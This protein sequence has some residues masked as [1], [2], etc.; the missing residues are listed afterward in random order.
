[1]RVDSHNL[2]LALR[3]MPSNRLPALFVT[4]IEISTTETILQVKRIQCPSIKHRCA[5]WA[6]PTYAHTVLP[7]AHY[8]INSKTDP[9]ML[10]NPKLIL[11]T[12]KIWHR[13]KL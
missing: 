1:M 13:A 6:D 8:I 12:I 4:E 2:D 9:I 7:H 5:F 11:K 3:G 10:C